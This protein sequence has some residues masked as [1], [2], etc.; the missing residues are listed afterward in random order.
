MKAGTSMVAQGTTEIVPDMGVAMTPKCK[1]MGVIHLARDLM[2]SVDLLQMPGV[3][4]DLMISM[5]ETIG[6]AGTMEVAVSPLGRVEETTNGVLISEVEAT[7]VG[8]PALPI[9]IDVGLQILETVAGQG[10]EGRMAGSRAIAGAPVDKT[11]SLVEGIMTVVEI[12]TG[13]VTG[14]EEATETEKGTGAVTETEI[15]AVTETEQGVTE[16]AIRTGIATGTATGIE[17]EI[18]A[19][20]TEIVTAVNHAS[21]EESPNGTT[22][23]M[24]LEPKL[25]M[26]R[27]SSR[28]LSKKNHPHL[29][30]VTVILLPAFRLVSSRTNS[31]SIVLAS[32]NLHRVKEMMVKPTFLQEAWAS[33]GHL[34][35]QLLG[36]G[37]L[38]LVSLLQATSPRTVLLICH[39]CWMFNLVTALLHPQLQA[40]KINPVMIPSQVLVKHLFLAQSLPAL[41]PAFKAPLVVPV[42]HRV[43]AVPCPTPLSHPHGMVL[44]LLRL[45]VETGLPSNLVQDPVSLAPMFQ[46]VMLWA[47]VSAQASEWKDHSDPCDPETHRIS[48]DHQVA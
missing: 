32:I 20:V 9:K 33:T 24:R 31:F 30:S 48:V 5:V 21:V 3:V 12:W 8:V 23:K 27:V 7:I 35:P 36:Q 29:G 41:L 26:T 42:H 11:D 1:V 28:Q 10:E 45:G 25:G 19:V 2:I 18:E 6:K 46:K 22:Q 40:A 15:E 14:I 34:L 17:S 37:D 44:L 4:A 38:H 16:T 43:R 13:A 47:V 39:P